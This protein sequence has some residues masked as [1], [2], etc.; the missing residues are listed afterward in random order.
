MSKEHPAQKA[1][2]LTA[3]L[4]GPLPAS[5]EQIVVSDDW[6]RNWQAKIAVKIAA[7][8]IWVL[9]ATAFAGVVYYTNDLDRQVEKS[10]RHDLDGL[11][12]RI[13][14]ALQALPSLTLDSSESVLKR[15][16]EA[17]VSDS[18]FDGITLVLGQEVTGHSAFTR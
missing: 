17:E 14:T 16:L 5:R 1:I 10:L 8:F 2:D 18:D 9:I 13:Q 3:S 4:P 12:Y 11:G 6:T 15:V 7:M